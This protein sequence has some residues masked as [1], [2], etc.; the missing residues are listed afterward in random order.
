MLEFTS[1]PQSI[2]GETI[3]V[4]GS[5]QDVSADF[6]L[7]STVAVWLVWLVATIRPSGAFRFA[8]P[9]EGKSQFPMNS[10]PLLEE[11]ER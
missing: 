6:F 9:V 1:L 10:S 11:F 3:G 8:F 2:C 5:W 7:K 4:Q